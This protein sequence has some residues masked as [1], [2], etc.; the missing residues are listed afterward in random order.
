MVPNRGNAAGEEEESEAT[1]QRH[2]T[3]GHAHVD[4]QPHCPR[5]GN[6]EHG[7]AREG[8]LA[9]ATPRKTNPAAPSDTGV[10]DDS[11]APRDS[12][13]DSERGGAGRDRRKREQQRHRRSVTP[14]TVRGQSGGRGGQPV[15]SGDPTR[16]GTPQHK[17]D[18]DIARPF[19]GSLEKATFLTEG[20]TDPTRRAPGRGGQG[21]RACVRGYSVHTQTPSQSINGQATSERLRGG[22]AV[23]VK[24]FF[25]FTR[26]HIEHSRTGVPGPRK[27]HPRTSQASQTH[28]RANGGEPN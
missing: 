15:G 28:L 8:P 7:G 9:A 3:S 22:P 13:S 16:E 26:V 5:H 12:S 14:P 23:S 6:G 17:P 24:A 19:L 20:G 11:S 25:L 21:Q 2:C 27:R 1:P 18:P 4:A 10:T